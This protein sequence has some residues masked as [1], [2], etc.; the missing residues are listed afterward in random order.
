MYKILTSV[1]AIFF[2]L[3]FRISSKLNSMGLGFV[4]IFICIWLWRLEF[5]KFYGFSETWEWL[6]VLRM[7]VQVSLLLLTVNAYFSILFYR[8]S[9][10][11]GYFLNIFYVI[12]GF[13][14]IV[15]YFLTADR[16]HSHILSRKQ[17]YKNIRNNII[18]TYI[19]IE[20]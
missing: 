18:S 4:A 2:F 10:H 12:I 19:F 13:C 3:Q 9:L 1:K 17:H 5:P 14:R 11:T 15:V 20:D 16:K 7:Y 8:T 6:S